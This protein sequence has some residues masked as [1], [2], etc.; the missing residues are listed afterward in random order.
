MSVLSVLQSQIRNRAIFFVGAAGQR[1]LERGRVDWIFV[2]HVCVC[3]FEAL[4]SFPHPSQQANHKKQLQNSLDKSR[5]RRWNVRS[6]RFCNAFLFNCFVS[7]MVWATFFGVNYVRT[8]TYRTRAAIVT[9]CQATAAACAHCGGRLKVVF[10]LS[11]SAA[12]S[13]N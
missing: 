6:M 10:I 12:R 7:V 8:I 1:E 13:K 9:K 5:E 2:V 4:L 11:A 3:V